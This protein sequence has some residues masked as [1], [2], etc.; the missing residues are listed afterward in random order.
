MRCNLYKFLFFL[1][2][3]SIVASA[4]V[5]HQ[6]PQR[7]KWITDSVNAYDQ[8][9]ESI[10]HSLNKDFSLTTII[11][12]VTVGILLVVAVVLY[13]VYR[14]NRTRLELL[15][16]AWKKFDY[17]VRSLK[18]DQSIITI[19]KE[20]VL[21]SG[22]QNPDSVIRSPN[23]FESSLEKYYKIKKIESMPTG[24]LVE[25]RNLR[26][27]L[28]FL[29]LSKE[30]A[31]TSTRQF[32]K[33]EKFLLQIPIDGSMAHNGTCTALDMEELQWSISRPDVPPIPEDTWI[34][35]NLTRPGDA[36][37]TFKVQVKRDSGSRLDLSHTS[38]LNRTQQRN[39]VRI[40]VSIP[41]EVTVLEHNSIGDIFMGKIIDMSGGGLGMALPI[42]LLNNST[43]TLNLELPGH[44]FI[45]NLRV[46]VVRVAGQYNNDPSKTIHSV[47]F[48]ETDTS[49]QEQIIQ[50]VFEKQRQ[51][52]L[53][54]H[55]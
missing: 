8:F 32:N 53:M 27:S 17:N 6:T 14:A 47:A 48:E 11:I 46:K 33:D 52:S 10:R 40:D 16:L 50:Y 9:A 13:E 31:F 37:Y 3:F 30:I 29:P 38:Q 5:S 22:L 25:I 26:R 21:V 51:D 19:L 1:T 2:M 28:N 41:V 36:E 12:F 54:K 23:V 42:K 43:L 44:G 55:L 24:K 4:Q 34:T 7:G 35:M 15:D 49:V 45:D 18:L 39:W 20:I